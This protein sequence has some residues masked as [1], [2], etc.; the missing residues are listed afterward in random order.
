M[1]LYGSQAW[2]LVTAWLVPGHRLPHPDL[3]SD[4]PPNR[5]AGQIRR[6]QKPLCLYGATVLITNLVNWLI[7]NVDR[8]IIGRLFSSRE[9]GLYATTYNMLYTPTTSLLGIINPFF[10][11]AAKVSNQPEVIA[12]SY[13]ALI[14]AVAIFILPAFVCLG[15]ITRNLCPGP[16][17]REMEQAVP[18][19][20]PLAFAMPLFLIWGFTTPCSGR[21]GTPAGNSAFNSPSPSSGLPP[22][23]WPLSAR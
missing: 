23:G 18:L 2:A 15:A 10:S 4:P 14:G 22:A 20:R 11:A 8:V 17:R 21:A 9:I 16:L 12:S 1:A 7:N 19:F 6:R 5:P 13:R 3:F